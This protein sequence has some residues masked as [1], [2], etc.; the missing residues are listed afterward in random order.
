MERRTKSNRPVSRIHLFVVGIVGLVLGVGVVV[1]AVPLAA[2]ALVR[3][4]GPP[5]TVATFCALAVLAVVLGRLARV[6]RR[7]R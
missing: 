4:I 6:L 7:K 1:I 5:W 2:G 3:S